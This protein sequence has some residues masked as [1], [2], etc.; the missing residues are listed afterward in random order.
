MTTYV[1]LFRGINVGGKN[2]LPME[3]L[4]A[5]LEGI[6]C[7]KVKTYIQSG[8]AVFR[9]RKIQTKK[10]EEKISSNIM[11]RYG[12][13]PKVLLLE[14][15][16]LLDAV[17]NN[18]FNNMDGKALHFFFLESAPVEPNLDELASVKSNTEK[19]K[20]DKNIFYLYAPDGIGRSKL[21][22]KVEQALGVPVTARNWNTVSKLVTL[23]R[24]A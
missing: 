22:A 16:E 23:A 9:A 14:V 7:D 3:D 17:E 10:F 19:F 20:L 21:A 4:V 6:G 1:A 5:I 15:Q 2:I 24:Q 13:R 11:E 18:P 8:N 12:F